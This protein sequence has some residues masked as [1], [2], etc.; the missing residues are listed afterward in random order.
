MTPQPVKILQVT[1]AL[2]M[3]GAETWLMELLRLWSKSGKV[4][5]DFLLTSGNRGIFDDEAAALR[6]API[7]QLKSGRTI[8]AFCRWIMAHISTVGI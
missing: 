8:T 7:I 3:G 4:Q 2:G 1:H 6:L 5:M